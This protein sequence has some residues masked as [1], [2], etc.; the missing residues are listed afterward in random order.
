MPIKSMKCASCGCKY[1]QFTIIPDDHN[2]LY[3]NKEG[4]I[5]YSF[6]ETINEG[7]FILDV[8]SKVKYD[9]DADEPF[10]TCD[11]CEDEC[12]VIAEFENGYI[13]NNTNEAFKK[14]MDELNK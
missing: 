14:L 4:Y 12:D 5:T 2:T 11:E 6:N 9:N 1:C 13:T 7:D 10:G 3:F 8:L